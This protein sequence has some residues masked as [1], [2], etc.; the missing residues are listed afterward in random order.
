MSRIDNR[1]KIAITQINND[2]DENVKK[3][4][5]KGRKIITGNNGKVE[6]EKKMFYLS[7][8][9]TRALELYA[10]EERKNSS[11][12]CTLALENM[13]PKHFIE[14]ADKESKTI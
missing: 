9:L 7:K 2:S 1:P 11:E 8:I 10:C 12:I 3:E 13:I 5:L 14:R 4:V 6:K